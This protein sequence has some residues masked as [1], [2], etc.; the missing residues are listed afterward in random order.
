MDKES[1]TA[2]VEALIREVRRYLVFVQAL[3][4]GGPQPPSGKGPDKSV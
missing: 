1:R 4:A 2:E 3:R